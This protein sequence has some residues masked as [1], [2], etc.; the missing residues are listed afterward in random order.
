MGEPFLAWAAAD[1]AVFAADQSGNPPPCACAS[2][3]PPRWMSTTS[4][5][6]SAARR[7]SGHAIDQ[8]ARAYLAT[9]LPPDTER[10]IPGPGTASRK[11][12]D[13]PVSLRW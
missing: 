7:G 8:A 5:A 13:C 11:F 1:R 9:Y 3:T 2:V 4:M 6:G 10:A 12:Y